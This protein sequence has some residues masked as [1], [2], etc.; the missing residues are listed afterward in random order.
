[1]PLVS[2]SELMKTNEY[3]GFVFQREETASFLGGEVCRKIVLNCSRSY[4]RELCFGFR[5]LLSQRLLTRDKA[6]V[7]YRLNG[8][9]QSGLR[10][11]GAFTISAMVESPNVSSMALAA[12]SSFR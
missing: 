1:M 8:K 3:V 7:S 12:S 9:A 11:L 5:R 4:H 10:F 6:E 2:Q